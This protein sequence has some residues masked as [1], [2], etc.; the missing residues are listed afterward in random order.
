MGFSARSSFSGIGPDF[1]SSFFLNRE[2]TA[3]KKPFFPCFSSGGAS[4]FFSGPGILETSTSPAVPS[5]SIFFEMPE[6][7]LLIFSLRNLNIAG[8][9]LWCCRIILARFAGGSYARPPLSWA[10]HLF[11]ALNGAPMEARQLQHWMVRHPFSAGGGH[12]MMK[13]VRAIVRQSF[14]RQQ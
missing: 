9:Y 11:G 1:S 5:S 12:D 4:S 14:S 10:A 13:N 7:A 8:F 3:E 6:T 2:V